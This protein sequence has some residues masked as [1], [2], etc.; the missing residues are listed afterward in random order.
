[1]WQIFKIRESHHRDLSKAN[2]RKYKVLAFELKKISRV[3][4]NNKKH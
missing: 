3:E 2:K 4:D 1:M